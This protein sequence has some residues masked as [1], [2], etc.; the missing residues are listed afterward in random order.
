M[1]VVTGAIGDTVLSSGS[2]WSMMA[3][4]RLDFV[5]VRLEQLYIKL[6]PTSWLN[7]FFPIHSRTFLIRVYEALTAK[8]AQLGQC[9]EL[10]YHLSELN[11]LEAD[12]NHLEN[13]MTILS[14]HLHRYPY[15]NEDLES[16]PRNIARH[17][18]ARV[19]HFNLRYFLDRRQF[20]L[21]YFGSKNEPLCKRLML[22]EQR[23]QASREISRASYSRMSSIYNALAEK[24]NSLQEQN[25]ANHND[26]QS[27][28]KA[29]EEI[30]RDLRRLN[31][32]TEFVL[33][34]AP[35]TVRVEDSRI[36]NHA[37]QDLEQKYPSSSTTSQL[38]TP[39]T[40]RLPITDT[41]AHIPIPEPS[42]HASDPLRFRDS[43]ELA[44]AHARPLAT[45]THS[46]FRPALS[47]LRE[48]A[49]QSKI[50]SL[51]E[52]DTVIDPFSDSQEITTRYIKEGRGMKWHL[53][54]R[55]SKTSGFGVV[56]K[57]MSRIKMN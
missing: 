53:F 48:A 17:L 9:A 49:E 39:S 33:T 44:V 2:N 54:T 3:Q 32:A 25:I 6:Q 43:R 50:L 11:T 26:Y 7:D 15:L 24:L 35:D 55:G 30:E 18:N 42:S 45:S 41:P 5:S 19:S 22:V 38:R 21:P 47:Q 16:F 12:A 52:G 23:I 29:M 8:L 14:D 46:Q 36:I 1:A 56:L 40:P 51:A 10:P 4:A 27:H 57:F 13:F 28:V 37:L 20:Y 34:G 31:Q